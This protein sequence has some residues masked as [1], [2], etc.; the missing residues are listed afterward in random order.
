MEVVYAL[1]SLHSC[2]AEELEK[3]AQKKQKNAA[4][5]KENNIPS[6]GWIR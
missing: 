3:I 1:A 5:L 2:T 6:G 4:A